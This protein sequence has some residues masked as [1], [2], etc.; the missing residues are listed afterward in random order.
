MKLEWELEFK[1]EIKPGRGDIVFLIPTNRYFPIWL[2][3]PHQILIRNGYFLH[4]SLLKGDN[5]EKGKILRTDSLDVDTE[6][7]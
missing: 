3:I 2:H 5:L 7:L 6:L 4:L 1:E